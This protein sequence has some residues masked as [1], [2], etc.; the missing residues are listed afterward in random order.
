[1]LKSSISHVPCLTFPLFSRIIMR[2]MSCKNQSCWVYLHLNFNWECYQIP[3]LFCGT[4]Y[5]QDTKSVFTNDYSYLDKLVAVHTCDRIHYSFGFSPLSYG[6]NI[7]KGGRPYKT[8][9][10][11]GIDVRCALARPSL[12]VRPC[13]MSLSFSLSVKGALSIDWSDHSIICLKC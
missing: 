7:S 9:S 6:Q 8:G 5:F 12:W 2:Q 3:L 1:M 10:T 13:K 4:G 11:I